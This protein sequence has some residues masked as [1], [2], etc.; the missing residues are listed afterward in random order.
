MEKMLFAT[1]QLTKIGCAVAPKLYVNTI[2]LAYTDEYGTSTKERADKESSIW[3]R[4]NEQKALVSAYS[5]M[6]L[7]P[8]F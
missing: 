5:R 7:V 2:E 4:V 3:S 6:K 1:S 8:M